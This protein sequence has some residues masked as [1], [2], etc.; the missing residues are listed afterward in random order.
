M[1]RPGAQDLKAEH[2]PRAIRARLAAATRHSY[3]RDF[4]LGAVDGAVT[5]FTYAKYG[6][7]RSEALPPRT[8]YDPVTGQAAISQEVRRFTPVDTGYP[9]LNDSSHGSPSSPAPASE[10][11]TATSAT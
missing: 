6:R 8:I 2:T 10:L 5:T 11:R 7:V 4:V 9:L 1:D 3:V